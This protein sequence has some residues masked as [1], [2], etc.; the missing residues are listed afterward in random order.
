M[1]S[2]ETSRRVDLNLVHES[3]N[4]KG[5]QSY[6]YV[7]HIF[8]IFRIYLYAHNVHLLE[9]AQTIIATTACDLFKMLV[10]LD[11]CDACNHDACT[12]EC[13][14]STESCCA[15]HLML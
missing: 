15:G 14:S 11:N 9:D 1:V 12:V 13:T 3:Q 6:M 2:R 8:V 7:T 5:F 10:T 4:G